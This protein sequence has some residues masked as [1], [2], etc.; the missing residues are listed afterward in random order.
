M[1]EL[2][3]LLGKKEQLLPELKHYLHHNSTLGTVLQS[4]L[5][6]SV[7]HHSSMNAFC[8]AQYQEKKRRVEESRD[9]KE[10]HQ[11]VFWHERPFR[12]P[13]FTEICNELKP[14]EYWRLL[15][16]IWIDTEYAWQYK[17]IWEMLLF[18]K[19]KKYR[20][21]K[22]FFMNDKDRKSF[23]GM[24]KG[25]K[26]YRGCIAKSIT[27]FSWTLNRERAVWFATRFNQKEAYLLEGWVN[28]DRILAVIT[29]RNEDE[30]LVHPNAVRN[31]KTLIINKE[32]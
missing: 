2:N 32:V 1:P 26:I 21:A 29:G 22:H 28:K 8:N 24:P 23:I 5:L 30:I 9:L 27:G 25:F 4:P 16:D 19:E 7:P 3:E 14:R 31:I 13:A 18:R 6:F 10:W 15:A 17:P 20:Q 11:F 12:L